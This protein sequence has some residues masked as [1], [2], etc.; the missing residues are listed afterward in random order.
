MSIFWTGKILSNLRTG[1]DAW[2]FDVSVV[3]GKS[4]NSE[5]TQKSTKNTWENSEV[6][7]RRGEIQILNNTPLCESNNYFHI[8]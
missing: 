7:K 1:T 8:S 6:I 5:R 4:R 3:E 2:K